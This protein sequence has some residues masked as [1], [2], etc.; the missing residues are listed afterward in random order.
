MPRLW[1][2]LVVLGVVALSASGLDA[3]EGGTAGA[4]SPA[5]WSIEASPNPAGSTSAM[6]AGVSC[7]SP[8]ACTAVGDYYD[9]TNDLLTLAE[10][11]DGHSWTIETT[12]NAPNVHSNVLNAVS[13]AGPRTCTA[14]G[15]SVTAKSRIRALVE[16]W[17]GTAWTLEPTPPPAGAT[18][19]ELYGVSCSAGSACEAV[20]EYLKNEIT[21]QYQ[22]LAETWNGS[23]WTVQPAPNPQAENGSSLSSVS[24]SAVDACTA[25]GNYAYAD[26]AQSIF[27]FRWDGTSWVDQHQPNP[28]GNDDNTA[29]G[30]SCPATSACTTVGSWV[31]AGDQIK[32]LAERWDGTVWV[33]QSTP[34]P[35]GAD[36]SELTGVSCPGSS[37]CT[38]VGDAAT[39]YDQDPS[40]PL[41][42][43]WDGSRWSLQDTPN[44]PGGQISTLDAVVCP[45]VAT[46]VAVGDFWNGS[47][48]AT[49]VEN[50]SG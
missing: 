31:N 6:L 20:G 32:T 36:I 27:A 33:R 29:D 23:T 1:A 9:S 25:G 16:Q 5:G 26:V 42:E 4:D 38:A 35:A 46:C 8:D 28:G 17:N 41:A 21:G 34:N 37:T 14:V 49:L 39:N 11:W 24:C 19:V 44:P 45:T 2:V 43:H 30:V 22:P 13:C 7:S 50:Y 47:V 40:S 48:T 10:R 15:Y 12:P 3:A 18:A